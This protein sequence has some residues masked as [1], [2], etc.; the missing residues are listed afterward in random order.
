MPRRKGLRGIFVSIIRYQR[1]GL[2]L[3]Q[4]LLK[5]QLTLRH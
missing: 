2:H 1:I 4:L 3:G 5:Q